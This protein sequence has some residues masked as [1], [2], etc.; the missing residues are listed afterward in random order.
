MDDM[1]DTMGR[2]ML[3]ARATPWTATE[4]V[5]M[6]FMWAIM[7]V[8]M[9]LPSAAPMML[10]FATVNRRRRSQGHT[11]TPAAVFAAGYVGVW[12]T[13]SLGATLLQWGLHRA[14][15]LSQM[16]TTTSAVLGGAVLVAAGIYQ[17]TPFK[18]SCLRHCQSPL[19]FISQH[20]RSG[21]AGAFPDG[22]A[23]R[24]VLS[25]LL[26]V[27]HGTPVRGWGDEPAVDRRS[28][29]VR[30]SGESLA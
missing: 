14:G 2:A 9:M 24:P 15:L 28:G 30:A 19:H 27:S 10:L 20:W 23:A 18:N 7:M 29:S 21:T 25:R 8:A 11:A 12:S 22:V 6:F 17:W 3:T 4:F 16:M 26:L 1:G 13:F 5:L